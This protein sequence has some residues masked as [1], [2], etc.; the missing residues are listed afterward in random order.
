[1]SHPCAPTPARLALLDVDETTALGLRALLSTDERIVV[2]DAPYDESPFAELLLVDV[3]VRGERST[4]RQI[5]ELAIA[6]PRIIAWTADARPFVSRRLRAIDGVVV[7]NRRSPAR[8]LLAALGIEDSGGFD[9]TARAADEVQLS[10]QEARVLR[11]FADG[12]TMQ[13]V[14]HQTGI[15]NH[16]VEDYIR[17]IRSK[18]ERAGRPAATKSD[19][20]K[21]AI[22]DGHLPIPDRSPIE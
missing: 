2:L 8:G 7:L 9:R 14:A 21:R 10:P 22:E 18:Y 12:G 19:L 11:I 16:T 6:G 4:V 15:T 20:L 3:D 13:N 1:M 5:R 17:R